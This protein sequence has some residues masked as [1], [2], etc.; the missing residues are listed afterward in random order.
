MPFWKNDFMDLPKI[1][2]KLMAQFGIEF[3]KEIVGLR[4]LEMGVYDAIAHRQ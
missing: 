2:M 1:K 4:Q 3:L